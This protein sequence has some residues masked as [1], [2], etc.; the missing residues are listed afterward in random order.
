LKRLLL[1]LLGLATGAVPLRAVTGVPWRAPTY[2][3]TADRVP[4][5]AL[6]RA[7]ATQQGLPLQLNAPAE[8]PVSGRFQDLPARQFLDAV[9]E[10]TGLLWFWDGSR[11]HIDAAAASELAHGET[12]NALVDRMMALAQ[13]GHLD[14]E[15][16][17]ANAMMTKRPSGRIGPDLAFSQIR[18]A[19]ADPNSLTSL[20]V[21]CL[22][23]AGR[24][25]E[26]WADQAT[27]QGIYAEL[28]RHP[29]LQES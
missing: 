9:C 11:L 15:Q 17:F 4:A 16:N 14:P 13:H 26:E 5:A 3:T 28:L 7:F 25:A 22:K 2:S 21:A 23:Q 6:L 20:A 10:A 8:T 27:A 29:S 1:V 19:T 18:R 24:P 12:G